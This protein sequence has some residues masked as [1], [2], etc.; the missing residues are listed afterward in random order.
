MEQSAS[1]DG[2]CCCQG[3][4]IL[5]GRQTRK[6]EDGSTICVICVPSGSVCTCYGRWEWEF[7][8]E[9]T[10]LSTLAEKLPAVHNMRCIITGAVIKSNWVYQVENSFHKKKN[11]C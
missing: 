4:M 8:L 6:E 11:I 9:K 2:W 3:N 1:G 10:S 7:W 5:G